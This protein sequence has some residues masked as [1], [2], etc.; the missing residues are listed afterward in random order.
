MARYLI[1]NGIDESRIWK[2]EVSTSTHENIN[3]AK[4]I[5]AEKGMDVENLKVAIV[6]NEFHLFRA[7]LTGEKAGLNT[8]GVA[9]ET[10]GLHRRVIY[11]FRETF[12][13]ANELL[14]R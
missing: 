8:F 11:Y 14:F 4:E 9:A 7:K 6:S 10:P 3:F 2:E 1:A 5:M 12:S 13:L